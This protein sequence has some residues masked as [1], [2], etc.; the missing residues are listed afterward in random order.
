MGFKTLSHSFHKS[1]KPVKRVSMQIYN[2]FRLTFDNI[3]LHAKHATD[4]IVLLLG[5]HAA[6]SVDDIIQILMFIVY[7]G[8]YSAHC[9][10]RSVSDMVYQEKRLFLIEK[11][12][13]AG[14][15]QHGIHSGLPF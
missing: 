10:M 15:N 7:I 6:N 3:H 4:N 12:P 9:T 13:A 5:M 8:T 2:I 14:T 11:Q 1:F